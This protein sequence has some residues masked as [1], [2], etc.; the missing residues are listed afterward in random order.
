MHL[1]RRMVNHHARY[2]GHLP[3]ATSETAP[4]VVTLMRRHREIMTMFGHALKLFSIKG[5]IVAFHAIPAHLEEQ[6][7][8]FGELKN[9]D[10]CVWESSN[11]RQ[12]REPFA[13]QNTP[14]TTLASQLLIY[15]YNEEGRKEEGREK[16]E[17][18]RRKGEEGKVVKREESSG[19][20][21]GYKDYLVTPSSRMEGYKV[22]KKKAPGRKFMTKMWTKKFLDDVPINLSHYCLIQ[23]S[24]DILHLFGCWT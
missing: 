15:R 14:G 4:F 18:R 10:T 23:S 19:Y 9:L 24:L 11:K 20:T 1:L 21:M 12:H 6:I 13:L 2:F 17:G 22:V 5:H 3:I 16:K 8:M 7:E